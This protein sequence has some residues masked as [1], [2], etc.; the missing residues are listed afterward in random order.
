M[1]AQNHGTAGPGDEIALMALSMIGKPY[2]WG[3][4]NPG[5][6]FDCSGL[7]RHV[8]DQAAGITLPRTSVQM[9]KKG[10]PVSRDG[11]RPGDLV[12]FS[13]GR[14]RNSHVGV[15]VGQ[16]RFVHAPAS[17]KRI[18]LAEINNPY[19]SRVYSQARRTAN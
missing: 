5:K 12:F 16:G 7:V 15:Y 9:A 19:W 11:L 6:G 17:G 13:P 14:R 1:P 8:V 10:R 2:I 3:G 18:R 4:Q